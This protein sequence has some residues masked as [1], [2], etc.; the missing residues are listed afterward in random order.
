MSKVF[1]VTGGTRGIGAAIAK[2]AAAAGHSVFVTG[3]DEEALE[4]T[5]ATDRERIAG[6]RADAADWQQTQAAVAAARNRFG[7]ID[8]AVAN[9][10]TGAPGTLEDGNVDR[11]RDV[12]LTNVLGV[13]LTVKACLSALTETRGRIVLIGSVTGRKHAPGSL[14]GATKWAITGLGES[15]RLQVRETG[16]GI[17]VIEPGVVDT[18]FWPSRDAHPFT[19]EQPL[20]ADDIA[21]AVLFAVDQP[22]HVDVNE[23]LIR[24]KGQPL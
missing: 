15:L 9:A 12:V 22:R 4:R 20:S 17:T 11:W 6:C 19:L 1:F 16:I 2:N 18:D 10:G 8:V 7:Q 3:R 23:I 13:A 14:Y 5:V 21:A 24:A